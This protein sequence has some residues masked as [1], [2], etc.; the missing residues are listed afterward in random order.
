LGILGL[1]ELVAKY[2]R[3]NLFHLIGLTF[4]ALRLQ[5][6]YLLNPRPNEYVVITPD[7]FLKTEPHQQAAHGRK[8]NVRVRC[9][10]QNLFERLVNSAHD[11]DRI[12]PNV[13]NRR[14]NKKGR[15]DLNRTGL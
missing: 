9:S 10:A 3:S 13:R 4:R 8:R 15:F 11:A 12:Y 14:K 2:N 6:Q 5:I 1:R 7:A